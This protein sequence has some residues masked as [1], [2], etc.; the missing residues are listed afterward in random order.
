MFV[1]G[2]K[3]SLVFLLGA[4][5]ALLF[6][7]ASLHGWQVGEMALVVATAGY[8]SPLLLFGGV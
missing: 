1:W 5:L 3:H 6:A 2:G 7:S 8:R 4:G